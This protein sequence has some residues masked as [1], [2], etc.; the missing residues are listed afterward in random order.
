[1]ES[2]RKRRVSGFMKGKLIPLY[3]VGNNHTTKQHKPTTN[4]AVAP[5]PKQKVLSFIVPPE[6]QFEHIFGVGDDEGVDD[7][8]DLYIS[9]VQA[10]FKLER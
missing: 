8:A 4:Y 1:M 5:L 2:N 3:R 10:R 9:S 7:K 6:T